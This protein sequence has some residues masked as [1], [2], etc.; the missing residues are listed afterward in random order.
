MFLSLKSIN[1]QIN[2]HSICHMQMFQIEM[3][4]GFVVWDENKIL[5]FKTLQNNK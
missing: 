5:A 1:A 2:H 3:R 4:L